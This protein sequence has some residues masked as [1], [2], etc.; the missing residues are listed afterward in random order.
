M[1]DHDTLI[2]ALSADAG[3][4]RRIAPVWQ[5]LLL[6]IPLAL[7]L[8][9]A[10]SRLAYRPGTDWTGTLAWLAFANI[11]LSLTLG[12]ASFAA[13]L[14]ASVAGRSLRLGGAVL[15]G[16][17]AAWLGLSVFTMNLPAPLHVM[18]EH[19][20][21][22]FFFVLSAGIPMVAIAILALR[23]TR[24]LK[25]ARS[26][27]LAGTAIAF[28]SFGLLGFCHPVELSPVDFLTHLAAGLLLGAFTIALG[29][30]AIAA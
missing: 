2:D 30:K 7:V 17:G 18:P 8:G 19:G 3:P 11:A 24:A 6:W 14:S 15:A 26:L 4:V 5:R 21:S 1:V 25:P 22:C 12:F 28:L 29:R 10:G 16:L 9:F 27:A 23:R 20:A 13:A